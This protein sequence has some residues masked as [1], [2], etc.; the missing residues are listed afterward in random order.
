M[1]QVATMPQEKR[2]LLLTVLES[3]LKRKETI[4]EYAKTV[5][6]TDSSVANVTAPRKL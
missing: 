2:H 5:R 6:T 3:N 4:G 1:R